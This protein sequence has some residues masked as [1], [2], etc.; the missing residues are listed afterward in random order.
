[1][2]TTHQ[3]LATMGM[4]L[5]TTLQVS[6]VIVRR[7]Q[8]LASALAQREKSVVIE[9]DDMKLKFA[10]LVFWQGFKWLVL[11]GLIAWIL[12]LAIAKDY[13]IDAS[14][15]IK[16]MVG[17]TFDGKITLT[18]INNHQPEHRAPKISD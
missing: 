7:P 11:P 18:P 13:K 8:E 4:P 6:T 5:E 3:V 10:R 9:N 12:S 15:H 2:P 17:Q 1:M 16:W 14:W